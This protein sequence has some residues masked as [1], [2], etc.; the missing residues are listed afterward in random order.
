MQV[1]DPG[2]KKFESGMEKTRIRDKHPG[3]ATLVKRYIISPSDRRGAYPSFFVG[4]ALSRHCAGPP[5][6]PPA[7]PCSPA[8]LTCHTVT[9]LLG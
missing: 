4:R 7:A 1:R 2:W 9:K 8:G 5:R 3:S 6:W